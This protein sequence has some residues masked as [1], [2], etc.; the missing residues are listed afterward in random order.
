MFATCKGCHFGKY[1][2]LNSMILPMR[3]D[4]RNFHLSCSICLYFSRVVFPF[5]IAQREVF[6][7]VYS[8]AGLTYGWEILV[9]WNVGCP[10]VGPVVKEQKDRSCQAR[11]VY[12]VARKQAQTGLTP[13]R[14]PMSLSSTL[15]LNG[16]LNPT[17][18]RAERN[19]S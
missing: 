10:F 5:Q 16:S 3:F 7:R 13:Y 1:I 14:K 11:L 8:G 12:N 19:P 15:K 9:G 4:L 18:S 2:M 6:V 17:K